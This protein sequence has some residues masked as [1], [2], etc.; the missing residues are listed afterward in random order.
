MRVVLVLRPAGH[1]RG[2]GSRVGCWSTLAGGAQSLPDC[3]VVLGRAF[4]IVGRMTKVLAVKKRV[5]A[6]RPSYNSS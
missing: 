2:S 4:A 1:I 5:Y 6:T 3:I